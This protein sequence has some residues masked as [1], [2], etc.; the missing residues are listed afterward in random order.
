[1]IS[2][3]RR[4]AGSGGRW[5]CRRFGATNPSAVQAAR[6]RRASR[7][8]LGWIARGRGGRSLCLPKG[9]IPGPDGTEDEEASSPAQESPAAVDR[10]PCRK[11]RRLKRYVHRGPSGANLKH[12]A[13]D[14]GEL[15]DL[16]LYLTSTSLDVARRRGPWVPRGPG[17]PR[18]L[19]LLEG[20]A[21]FRR[22]P[23]RGRKEYGRWRMSAPWL[24]RRD[25]RSAVSC[26]FSPRPEGGSGRP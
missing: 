19:V 7:A 10:H 2:V 4:W 3:I 22:R 15:A 14:A 17:V 18:A 12:C 23:A 6:S 9:S 13:R 24:T 21:W 11:A 25:Y 5:G 16:R 26:R 20:S 1:M 8:S